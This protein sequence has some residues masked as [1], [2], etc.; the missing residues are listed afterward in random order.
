VAGQQV[1]HRFKDARLPA[2]LFAGV[3]GACIHPARLWGNPG[4]CISLP[5]KGTEPG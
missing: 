4:E 5:T 3:H 2:D 1:Q